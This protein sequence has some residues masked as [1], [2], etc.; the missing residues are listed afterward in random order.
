M[1]AGIAKAGQI[2][3]LKSRGWVPGRTDPFNDEHW[4]V[5]KSSP[6]IWGCRLDSLMCFHTSWDAGWARHEINW[7]SLS[8]IQP[9]WEPTVENNGDN[10]LGQPQ[11]LEINAYLCACLHT[12]YNFLFWK[13]KKR[14][15]SKNNGF[16][17]LK[18]FGEARTWGSQYKGGLGIIRENSLPGE[19]WRSWMFGLKPCLYETL[20]CF[21]LSFC[22]S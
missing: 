4:L 13:K 5:G 14:T 15:V 17:F 21:V 7:R 11:L 6:R 20:E 1:L 16:S 8:P 22:D 18:C 2:V 10:T 19:A 3:E 12:L 9:I